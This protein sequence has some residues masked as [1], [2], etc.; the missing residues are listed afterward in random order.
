MGPTLAVCGRLDVK[1]CR[2]RAR[3][4]G[5]QIRTGPGR[6]SDHPTEDLGILL[7]N[8]QTAGSACKKQSQQEVKSALPEVLWD[9]TD[10]KGLGSR[11]QRILNEHQP[12]GS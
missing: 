8:D 6:A 10:I 5:T 9:C 12:R 1:R 4:V 11:A 3:T 7:M 2:V